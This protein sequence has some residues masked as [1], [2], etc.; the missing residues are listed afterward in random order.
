MELNPFFLAPLLQCTS[1]DRCA[2]FIKAKKI[3]IIL[4]PGFYYLIPRASTCSFLFHSFIRASLSLSLIHFH[5]I[6][7]TL[8]LISLNSLSQLRSGLSIH[9][10][11][12][13]PSDPRRRS[14]TPTEAQLRSLDVWVARF[15]F[16]GLNLWFA[17][18]ICDL[19]LWV[20]FMVAVGLLVVLCW[21]WLCRIFFLFCLWSVILFG[22]GWGNR[23]EIWFFLFIYLFFI[24]AVD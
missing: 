11:N 23:L 3:Y 12:S 9:S 24:I 7:E 5:L 13:S 4:S 22:L 6:S 20:C 8:K 15:G 1:I 19:W 2:L 14:P 21:W 17:N 18:P 10:L 16:G